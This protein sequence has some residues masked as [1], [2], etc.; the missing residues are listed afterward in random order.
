MAYV[1]SHRARF[2]RGSATGWTCT[3]PRK[4]SLQGP[5]MWWSFIH[6]GN[7]NS[8]SKNTYTFVGRR[9]G[10]AG[11]RGRGYQLPAGARRCACPQMADDCARALA[12]TVQHIA[13]YGGDPA[14]VFVMG[15]SAGGGL[16]ALPRHRRRAAGPPRPAPQSRARRHSRR[17]RAGSDMHYLPDEQSYAGDTAVPRRLRQRARRLESACRPS[18]S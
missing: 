11:R 7:W 15:H 13:D 16:A 5:A 14:R 3:R 12:W 10:Q 18:T 9:A 2:R 17:P 8:G 1:A 4:K 6:G